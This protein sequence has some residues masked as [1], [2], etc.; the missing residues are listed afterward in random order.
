MSN[1]SIM[2]AI[3]QVFNSYMRLVVYRLAQNIYV[4]TY[5]YVHIYYIVCVCDCVYKHTHL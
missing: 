5:I 4:Y 2:V 1:F 3:F